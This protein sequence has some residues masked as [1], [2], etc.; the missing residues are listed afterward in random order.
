MQ[1]SA[2][3]R[4]F[5]YDGDH[6]KWVP[7]APMLFPKSNF[8]L[9]YVAGKIFC[10]GGLSMNEHPS[11]FVECYDIAANQWKYVARMPTALVDLNAVVHNQFVYV[12]GGRR[13]VTTH[14]SLL[15]LTIVAWT[16]LPS[17]PCQPQG[18]TLVRVLCQVKSMS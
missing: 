6:N 2:K 12:L 18:S 10:F 5:L 8:A 1:L 15:R 13:G 11:E 17:L 9:A 14:H 16:G 7:R 3:K 4:F